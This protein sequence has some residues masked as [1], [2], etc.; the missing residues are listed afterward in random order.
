[1]NV[2]IQMQMAGDPPD[3]RTFRGDTPPA[4]AEAITRALQRDRNLRWKTAGEMG[5]A[6][7][8]E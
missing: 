6:L 3:V 1:M 2:V 7:R 5:S 8:A 4:V